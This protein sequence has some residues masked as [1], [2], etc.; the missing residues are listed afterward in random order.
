MTALDL[1]LFAADP[2][3]LVLIKAVFALAFLLIMTLFTIW[4]ERRV[5]ALMQ[6]RKGPTMNGPFGI[7]SPRY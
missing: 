1:S 6:H 5:V 7:F 2:W 3:W 4:Y